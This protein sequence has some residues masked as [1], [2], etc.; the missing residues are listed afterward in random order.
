MNFTVL[1][2]GFLLFILCSLDTVSLQSN[3]NVVSLSEWFG[4]VRQAKVDVQILEPRGIQIWTKYRPT[5]SNFGVELLVNPT[6]SED[7][8]LMVILG[9]TIKY[10]V[11]EIEDSEVY[12]SQ[13]RTIFVDKSFFVQTGHYCSSQCGN[14]EDHKKI[15]FLK[16]YIEKMLDNCELNRLSENL[17][18]PMKHAQALVS[19]PERFVKTRLYSVD[20]LKPLVQRV[21]NVYVAEDGVGFGMQNIFEKL[22]VLDLGRN[23]LG[24]VD[25]DEYLIAPGTSP[26]VTDS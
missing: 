15:Q 10:R 9:D 3:E 1:S 20:S 4:F 22:T 11:V 25:F 13:W 7:D 14:N 12:W 5:V 19:N 6:D 24:V 23:Q 26:P 18:F 21:Q 8:D 17:F 2:L 16:E